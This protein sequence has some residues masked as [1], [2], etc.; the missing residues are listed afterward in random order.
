MVMAEELTSQVVKRRAL[1]AYLVA[2]AKTGDRAAMDKLV[3][4][5][6]PRLL[7]HAY[8]LLGDLDGARDVTQAAWID[9]LHG[10]PRLR[11][12]A[13]FRVYAMRIV[14]RKVAG[15]IKGRQ[16]DR[17]LADDWSVEAETAAEPLGEL[18]ADV[19]SVRSAIEKLPGGQQATLALFYLDEMS[20]GEVAIAL[21][22][23]A[24]TVKTRLM[25]ARTKLRQ[26]LKGSED[27]QTG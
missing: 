18:G 6:Q 26:L 25:H 20:I 10:L 9:I 11:N 13:A 2:S 8:R 3:R 24:G 21:D 27:D 16:R 14:S 12:V 5:L 22:I 19:Q 23:P 4:L 1:E 7:G 15:I 17:Q